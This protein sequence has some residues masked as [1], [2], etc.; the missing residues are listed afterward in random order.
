MLAVLLGGWVVL[1][2]A[3]TARRLECG[4]AI[5]LA[6][7]VAEA[8]SQ[9]LKRVVDQ[10]RPTAVIPGLDVHGYPHDPWGRAFP[11]AHTALTV[12]AVAA[13]WPWMNRAQ[14]GR[15]ARDGGPRPAE[16]GLHRRPLAHRCRRWRCRRPARGVRVLAGRQQLA[17][18]GGRALTPP[19]VAATVTALVD[20]GAL[21]DS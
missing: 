20:A 17:D 10:P 4:R 15:G 7:L 3:G 2:A 11:S 5:G 18:P 1:G 21:P 14:A 19:L 9:V 6:L 16:P 12:A 13:L 8:V